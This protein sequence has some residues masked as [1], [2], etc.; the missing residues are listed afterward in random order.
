MIELKDNLIQ[1]AI[2]KLLCI[3]YGDWITNMTQDEENIEL[4]NYSEL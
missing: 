3:T 2:W 4:V 1:S